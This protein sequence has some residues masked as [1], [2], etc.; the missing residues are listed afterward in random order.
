VLSG[1]KAPLPLEREAG[2]GFF[3]PMSFR[4][5]KT[6]VPPNKT[7]SETDPFYERL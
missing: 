7:K 5:L 4:S 1:W 3:L 6:R 2:R